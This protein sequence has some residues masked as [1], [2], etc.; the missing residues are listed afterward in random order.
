MI[1]F[2]GTKRQ[3]DRFLACHKCRQSITGECAT[4]EAQ[5]KQELKQKLESFKNNL[6]NK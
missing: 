1:T 4:H 2:K 6:T 3:L 5:T